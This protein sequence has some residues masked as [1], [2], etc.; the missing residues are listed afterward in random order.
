MTFSISILQ[1]NAHS[2]LDFHDFVSR[3]FCSSANGVVF[4]GLQATV[5]RTSDGEVSPI[6]EGALRPS[7]NYRGSG[8]TN[9]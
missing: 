8:R 3:T 1:I 2:K 9:D 4:N 6:D 5:S 7:T